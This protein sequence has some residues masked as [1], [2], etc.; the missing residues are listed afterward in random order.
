M[1]AFIEHADIYAVDVS[2]CESRHQL[3]TAIAHRTLLVYTLTS[4]LSRRST[5][6]HRDAF[7]YRHLRSGIAV[8]DAYLPLKRDESRRT[9]TMMCF[10]SLRHVLHGKVVERPHRLPSP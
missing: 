1:T 2:W 8:N 9:T 3:S 5:T 4:C 7:R 10:V 6:Y